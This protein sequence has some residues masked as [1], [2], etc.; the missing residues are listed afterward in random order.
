MELALEIIEKW[1]KAGKP[2]RM[3]DLSCIDITELPD[4][5]D[6]VERLTI[7][8]SSITEIKRLPS[9]L[10]RF[11][12]SYTDI[13]SLPPLPET[14]EYLDCRW[15]NNLQPF[16]IPLTVKVQSHFKEIQ[17]EIEEENFRARYTGEEIAQ[18]RINEYME[19]NN[20]KYLSLYGLALKEL[21]I[22]PDDIEILNC[23]NNYITSLGK[24]PS[25][26]RILYCHY[27]F[28]TRFENIP[29]TL[30]VMNCSGTDITSFEGIPDTLRIIHA[31]DCR[32]LKE[33]NYLPHSLK[34]L[35][36]KESYV[37]TI[38][39]IPPNVRIL[40]LFNTRIEHLPF[41]P[42]SVT[43]LDC[44]HCCQMKS[45]TNLPKNL[46][47]FIIG[48][49]DISELPLLP[50]GLLYL[51][52]NFMSILNGNSLPNSIEHFSCCEMHLEYD[53]FRRY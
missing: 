29:P 1:I 15:C 4:I 30:K 47:Y 42:D 45:I 9:K 32:E 3:L 21:P 46:K 50:D 24:L 52:V 38:K 44:E 36:L 48:V 14:L 5:P 20:R 6:E 11:N 43:K 12:C 19:G 40:D 16:P 33:I 27:T 22:L 41:L 34:E 17:E 13:Y 7:Y 49:N 18:M 2:R 23:G 8:G 51:E 10:R 26:L 37:H 39:Y 25:G 31:R 35:Y 53:R 28:I